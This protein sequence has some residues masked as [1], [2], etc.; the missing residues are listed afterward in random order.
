MTRDEFPRNTTT[1]SSL[2]RLRPCFKNDGTVTAGNASGLNDG[3]AA[4]LVGLFSDSSCEPMARIVAWAQ[5]GVAPEVMGTGPVPAVRK[6]VR[7]FFWE[8]VLNDYPYFS[9]LFTL[10]ICHFLMLGCQLVE[11]WQFIP[12][13]SGHQISSNSTIF[14]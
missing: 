9:S 7:T 4:V 3:A 2:A 1:T 5:A 11:T 6:A 10:S 13:F 14:N 8:V 12:L